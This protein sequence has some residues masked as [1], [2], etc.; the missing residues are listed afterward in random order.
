MVVFA[1]ADAL[2]TRNEI[3]DLDSPSEVH[4][5]QVCFD[6]VDLA[7]RLS[8]DPFET[9]FVVE[10]MQLLCVVLYLSDGQS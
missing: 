6:L 10:F 9:A 8:G 5:L 3:S 2:L 4:L 1:H 7:A